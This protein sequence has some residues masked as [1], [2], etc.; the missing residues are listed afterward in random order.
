MVI[1]TANV[2]AL[3]GVIPCTCAVYYPKPGRRHWILRIGNDK[4]THY[5]GYWSAIH[6][7]RNL[8]KEYVARK[9]WRIVNL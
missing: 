2:E 6:K 9:G 7:A 3:G 4:T 8:L 5:G 1:V